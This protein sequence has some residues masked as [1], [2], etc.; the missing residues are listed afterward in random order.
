MNI[1]FDIPGGIGPVIHDPIRTMEQVKEVTTGDNFT[2]RETNHYVGEALTQLREAVG[3]EATVLGFAGCPYT[4]ATYIVEGGSSKNFT[5]IKKMMFHQ[6]EVLH[7]L[8]D[9][10]ADNVTDYIR[11]QA[12]S[13]AQVVQIFDSWAAH[14]MPLDYDVF[15]AP[16]NK[17]IIAEVKKTHPDLPVILY[18]SGSGGLIERMADAQPDI[19]SID[20]SVDMSDAIRRAG[21]GFAYQGNLDPGVLFADK[22]F[23]AKRVETIARQAKDAGVR[24]LMNTGHGVLPT[25]PEENVAAFFEAAKSLKL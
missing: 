2:A 23:I 16:Y 25:T 20:H 8:L 24:H 21:T 12:D 7:A 1:P 22:D 10:L 6:P 13:G 5:H 14:L 15:C 9:K 17:R 4:L 19:L 3:N 18:I 11:Y